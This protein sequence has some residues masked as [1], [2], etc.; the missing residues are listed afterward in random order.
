MLTPTT[1]LGVRP[2]PGGMFYSPE[3]LKRDYWIS[4]AMKYGLMSGHAIMVSETPRLVQCI[5]PRPSPP[6]SPFYNTIWHSLTPPPRTT[7]PIQPPVF[8][9]CMSSL[10]LITISYGDDEAPRRYLASDLTIETGSETYSFIFIYGMIMGGVTV[11]L[12]PAVVSEGI[13][14]H[15]SQGR[16][17]AATIQT[18]RGYIYTS[19]L[20]YHI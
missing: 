20:F 15:T 18:L 4:Q 16:L 2:P 12:F 8:S 11:L 14:R 17:Y 5:T 9:T 1:T 10:S 19:S 13:Y 6:V 7:P 3:E